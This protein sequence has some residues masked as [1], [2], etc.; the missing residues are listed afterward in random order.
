MYVFFFPIRLLHRSLNS[1]TSLQY[2]HHCST[3]ITAVH[4]SLQYLHHC[5][6]YITAV[7]TSLQYI[8]H[9]STYIT[10]V[11]TSLQYIHHCSTYITA[12]HTSLQYINHCSTCITT[13]HTSLQYMHHCSTYNTAVHTSLQYIHHCSTV[14]TAVHAS[15][16][17]IHHCS[18]YITAAHTSLQYI[19]VFLHIFILNVFQTILPYLPLRVA[20]HRT[21][22]SASINQGTATWNFKKPD[23]YWVVTV[24]FAG[25]SSF[26][27]NWHKIIDHFTRVPACFLSVTYQIFIRDKKMF[28]CEVVGGKNAACCLSNILL[29]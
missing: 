26:L 16:Q 19:H 9:C 22:T 24:N 28:Q 2:I 4:T 7:H 11:P 27:Q 12:V 3:Y 5:N 6:T 8:H 17:Y 13:V 25:A 23:L 21:D 20:V 15:L 14:I 18:T 1:L 29:A 10:A